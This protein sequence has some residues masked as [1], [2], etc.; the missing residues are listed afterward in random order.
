MDSSGVWCMDQLL[1]F[2]NFGVPISFSRS[3]SFGI[4]VYSE[5]NSANS[6]KVDALS[7]PLVC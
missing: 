6:S 1:A 2:I 5:I 3:F 7:N 4:M